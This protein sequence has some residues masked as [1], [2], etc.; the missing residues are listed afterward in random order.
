MFPKSTHET[1]CQK[2]YQTFKVHKRFVK[3]KLSRTDFT[4]SHYAGEVN[5]FPPNILLH[6]L[7]LHFNLFIAIFFFFRSSIKQTCFWTR[8]KT[9]WWLNIKTCWVP[10]NVLLYQAFSHHSLKR[11]VNLLSFHQL[12]IA[13][14]YIVNLF[15]YYEDHCK[16]YRL[17]KTHNGAMNNCCHST[18]SMKLNS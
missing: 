10:P 8:I 14:R 6:N 18:D 13:L 17:L 11:R 9:M 3:P 2:L 12:V 1:F 15:F 7:L 4:I 5:L 16:L